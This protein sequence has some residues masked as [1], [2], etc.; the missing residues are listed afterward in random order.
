MKPEDIIRYIFKERNIDIELRYVMD[1]KDKIVLSKYISMYLIDWFYPSTSRQEL[2]EYFGYK[3]K[4][5]SSSGIR[6]ISQNMRFN[7][8]LRRDMD[9]YLIYIKSQIEG[10]KQIV[11]SKV[12][13]KLDN[14]RVILKKTS[15]GYDLTIKRLL[16]RQIET[17]QITLSG[18]VLECIA[19]AYQILN[20]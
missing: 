3:A 14:K 20:K 17:R 4:S 2:S 8:E 12:S 1:N 7:K 5:N 11:G 13:I 19:N 10:K 6:K 15:L 16:N 9:K 18:E